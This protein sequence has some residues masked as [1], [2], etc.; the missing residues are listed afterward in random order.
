MSAPHAPRVP[1]GSSSTPRPSHRWDNG[2]NDRFPC[3][4]VLVA[5]TVAM[6]V[7]MAGSLADGG[8]QGPSFWI[9][10]AG[11]GAWVAALGWP[12]VVL[13]AL[14]APATR[15]GR[16][17]RQRRRRPSSLRKS[18]VR[19]KA[20]GS[21]LKAAAAFL[22]LG[23][24]AMQFYLAEHER[25]YR[26]ARLWSWLLL[27]PAGVTAHFGHRLAMKSAE[28]KL[29]Q[30][31]RAPILYL[32]SF[33][34]DD[35]GTYNPDTFLSRTLGCRPFLSGVLGPA[36]NPLLPNIVRM[37]LGRASEVA[38]EQFARGAEHLG[39]VIAIGRPGEL[40][41]AGG[42]ARLYVG[43]DGWKAKLQE[44][45]HQAQLVVAEAGSGE[46]LWW[47]IQEVCKIDRDKLLL[48]FRGLQEDQ[49][50]YDAFRRKFL[51][52]QGVALTPCARGLLF[53]ALKDDKAYFVPRYEHQPFKLSL[54]H[55]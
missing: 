37:I 55:I 18:P 45:M 36:A 47:E 9:I 24:I 29:R 53:I 43:D 27:L 46:H 42:A 14:F 21:L 52:E 33:V 5:A 30:D 20:F 2:A 51:T 26:S 12:L 19:S 28:E 48:S 7:G 22:L 32:R 44:L 54:I 41:A 11:M 35:K 13:G 4:A 6:L 23:A 39:P 15:L 16:R 1:S 38:E 34:H 40:I 31:S 8:G 10:P 50:V 17:E 49:A 25:Q 3:V